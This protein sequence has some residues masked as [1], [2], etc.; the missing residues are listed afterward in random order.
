MRFKWLDSSR[1]LSPS[2]PA[3]EAVGADVAHLAMLRAWGLI[4]LLG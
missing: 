4:S 1:E 3:L 2:V